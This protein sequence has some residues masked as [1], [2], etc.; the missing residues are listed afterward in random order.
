MS[1]SVKN[2][3]A[4]PVLY[5]FFSERAAQRNTIYEI[6]LEGCAVRF[7]GSSHE[8]DGCDYHFE[9]KQKVGGLKTSE[10]NKMEVRRVSMGWYDYFAPNF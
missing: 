6:N 10:F 3:Q 9:D 4:D 7:T 1:R 2:N 5:L 8:T